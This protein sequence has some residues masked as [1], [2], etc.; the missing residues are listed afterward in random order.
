MTVN[1]GYKYV[2]A[3]AGGVTWYMMESND[4]FSSVSF[5]FKKENNELVSLNG[6]MV[7]AC[8]LDYHSGKFNYTYTYI[9]L[10]FFINA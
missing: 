7:K 10:L 2:K 1:P 9:S 6:R 3:F 5:K 4:I 8:L